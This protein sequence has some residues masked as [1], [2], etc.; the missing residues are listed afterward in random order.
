MW[1]VNWHISTAQGFS[2]LCTPLSFVK[3]PQ[4]TWPRHE[5]PRAL[6]TQDAFISLAKTF[7]ARLPCGLEYDKIHQCAQTPVTHEVL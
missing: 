3:Y 2:L 4:S 7:N 6:S 1:C 5:E